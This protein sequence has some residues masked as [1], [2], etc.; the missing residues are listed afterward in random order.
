MKNLMRT[1]QLILTIAI[2]TFLTSVTP[3]QNRE[4]FGISAQ[5]GGVNAIIGQV[6]V[7]RSG[8]APAVLTNSDDIAAGDVVTTG[9][10]GYVEVLLNPGSYF[11]VRENSEFQFEDSSLDHLRLKLVKGSAI[12]EAT[13]IDDMDL[14]IRVV[15]SQAVFTIMRSGVYR[16]D[17]QP[18][19]A[20]LLVRKGR[21]AFGP[22]K[23]DVVKGG[24]KATF[25]NGQIARAK[26][27]KDDKDAFD[28]WSNQRA[29]LLARANE[30]LSARTFG[31]Y[32]ASLN[33]W[34]RRSWGSGWGIWAFNPRAGFYTFM[35]FTYGW[36]SPYGHHYGNYCYYP[37]WRGGNW[38]G[39]GNNS[40]RDSA[41]SSGG[42]GGWS[43]G[44]SSG[45]SGGSSSGGSF[46]GSRSSTPMSQPEPRS[47]RDS[48]P[49]SDIH[50][51]RQP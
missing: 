9:S 25:R 47:P 7:N 51:D 5:A 28:L 30:K 44:S 41:G 49:P 40:G 43:G 31:G 26:V 32:V 37:H 3:A 34:D 23:A 29:E 16:I 6:T 45:S 39:S 38:S 12:V 36:S 13:G 27:S 46:G 20:E 10:Q 35:P 17:A 11:R 18:D 21:A 2:V 8:Q 1:F 50:R 33:G 4:R 19:F 22:E 48:T 14:N 42:S 15:T 24:N